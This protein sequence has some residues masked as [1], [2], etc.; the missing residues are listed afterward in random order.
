MY[1]VPCAPTRIHHF[2]SHTLRFLTVSFFSFSPSTYGVS[3]YTYS[4]VHK[5]RLKLPPHNIV[6]L[7]KVLMQN[8]REGVSFLYYYIPLPPLYSIPLFLFL[9]K[10]ESQFSK[11]LTALRARARVH[12]RARGSVPCG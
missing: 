3:R 1:G 4:E 12:A 2:K 5:G 6:A 10:R 11:R 8:E 7:K 9:Q